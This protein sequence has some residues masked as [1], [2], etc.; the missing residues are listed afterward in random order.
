M[1]IGIIGSGHVGGTL[2]SRWARK[3]HE[4]VFGS[5]RPESQDIKDLIA[6]S[7]RT[8]TAAP[9][10]KAARSADILLLATPWPETRHVL[11]GLG[12]LTGKIVIDATNPLLP[13]LSGLEL[14]TTTSAAEQVAQWAKGAF[15]VKAFN[16]VGFGIMADPVFEAARV[17]MFYCSDHQETKS[18][19]KPL[20]EELGF[21]AL[22]AG[23][24]TQARVLEPFALL[25]ISLAHG[26]GFGVDI[27]FQFLRR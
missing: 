19:V 23:P 26:Q 9:L 21:D 25:W 12:D 5:R 13:D 4:V 10:A 3:G 20:I 17:A 6:K 18:K 14:G 11:N 8:A 24:L 22:D 7:G 15:V 1:Q 2:G 16:T 27:A